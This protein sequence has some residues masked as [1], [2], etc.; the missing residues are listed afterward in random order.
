[1]MIS[2]ALQLAS[3]RQASVM[4]PQA[5]S[6][7]QAKSA[8]HRGYD[9]VPEL[10]GERQARASVEVRGWTSDPGTDRLASHEAQER[11]SHVLERHHHFC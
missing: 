7:F 9:H 8:F 4:D 1:M 11:V 10:A 3:K 5:S 6:L 2:N